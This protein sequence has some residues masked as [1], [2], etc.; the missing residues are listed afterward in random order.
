MR[1]LIM[2]LALGLVPGMAFA[3]QGTRAPRA[4]MQGAMRGGHAAMLLEQRTALEL[5]DDQVAKLEA[6]RSS[7]EERN[8]PFVAE[9][10]KLRGDDVRPRDMT[11]EQREAMRATM[12]RMRENNQAA[13]AESQAVLTQQQQEKAQVLM[14]ER[15]RERRG[16]GMKG[17]GMR[18]DGMRGERRAPPPGGPAQGAPRTGARRGN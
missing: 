15:M 16:E 1:K 18:R 7:L 14:R 12:D 4:E 9:M 13:R 10:Q 8:A 2:A 11:Q 17:E 6:I 3:Q 5:T